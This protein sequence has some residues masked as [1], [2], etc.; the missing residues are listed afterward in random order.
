MASSKKTKKTIKIIKEE[1]AYHYAFIVNPAS[2][3]GRTGQRW[4]AIEKEIQNHN[5]LSRV[6]F[7]KMKGEA[8]DISRRQVQKGIPYIVAVGGDGTISE[9]AAG[10]FDSKG[11]PLKNSHQCALG[12]INTGSGCD[13]AKSLRLPLDFHE[14]IKILKKGFSQKVDMGIVSFINFEGK[15]TLRPF[16]NIADAGVGGEVVQLLEN[17]GKRWG[18]LAYLVA[19]LRTLLNYHNKTMEITLDEAHTLSGRFLGA[20]IANGRYF[21]SGMKIAPEADP[22]DGYFDVVLLGDI[23]RLRALVYGP[24]LRW[25]K[26]TRLKD[27]RVFHAKKVQVNCQEECL[28]DV[29]GELPGYCPAEFEIVPEAIRIVIP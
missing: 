8:S 2:A 1:P 4:P 17:Q 29:D 26:H 12:I 15:K 23:S 9:V 19:T 3:A 21:G 10:F 14:N 22:A 20:I 28:L 5:L 13:F 16:I 24:T 18:T 6:F 11:R 27:V 7:T 25:G